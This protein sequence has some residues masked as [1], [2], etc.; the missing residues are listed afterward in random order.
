VK[1][2]NSIVIFI[3]WQP[4][5]GNWP[6]DDSAI[7]I[8]EGARNLCQRVAGSPAFCSPTF[9]SSKLAVQIVTVTIA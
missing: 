3:L 2:S 5:F 4:P 6:A 1:W 8:A 9:D 7:S